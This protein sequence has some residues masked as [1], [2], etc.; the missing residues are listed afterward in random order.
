MTNNVQEANTKLHKLLA[1]KKIRELV[2]EV[3]DLYNSD[4]HFEFHDGDSFHGAFDPDSIPPKIFIHPL[5]GINEANIA[6]ELCHAIQVKDGFPFTRDFFNDTDNRQ[7]VIK[8]LNSNILHIPLVNLMKARGFDM[9][10]YLQ[11]T[12]TSIEENLEQ[13]KKTKLP[14]LRVH[15]EAAVYLRIE[16]EC[17]SLPQKRKHKIKM[18]FNSKA[19]IASSIGEEFIK[20]IN[21]YDPLV[22]HGNIKALLNCIVFINS[23]EIFPYTPDFITDFYTP[24][25]QVLAEQYSTYKKNL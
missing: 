2:R 3:E 20:I 13:R 25:L 10:E 19:P 15:Y 23:R 8:E 18:L 22:P 6:H 5:T 14:F 1:S 7:T 12:L 4:V 11:P 17:A 16:Y 9:L 21:A 24:Y